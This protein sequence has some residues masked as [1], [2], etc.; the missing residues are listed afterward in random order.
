ML[1]ILACLCGG[2]NKITASIA[3]DQFNDEHASTGLAI[4][5][6]KTTRNVDLHDIPRCVASMVGF[7]VIKVPY[8]DAGQDVY[9]ITNQAELEA[10]MKVSREYDK[11]LVQSLIGHSS[12]STSG[13]PTNFQ[14]SHVG[15]VPDKSGHSF[16]SDLRM[17]V[18][19]SPDGLIPISLQFRRARK[20][21]GCKLIGESQ[22]F[23]L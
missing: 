19:S 13:S 4:R 10:F 21:L 17:I 2:R 16:V 6:P 23:Q 3:F 8:S 7:A 20:P 9:I 18:S 12:W 14:Y 22:Y 15:T 1:W 5:Y 11:F